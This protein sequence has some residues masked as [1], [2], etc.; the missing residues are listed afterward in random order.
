[1]ADDES[2][3]SRR[4]RAVLLADMKDYSA[5]MGEDEA[6]AI[7]GVDD[8]AAVFQDVVRRRGGTYEIGSGDRFFAIFDSAVEAL[9]AALEIQRE[10]AGGDSRR[11]RPLAI[12]IGIHLGEVVVTSFGPMG[13]SINIAARIQSIAEPGGISV[14]E[15]VYR[16]VRSRLTD[17]AFRDTG[18]QTLKNI[19]ERI[20]VYAV[21]ASWRTDG[22]R[23]APVARRTVL[24]GVATL[25]AA[26]AG[27]VV[28]HFLPSRLPTI[29][30]PEGRPLVLGVMA[31]RANGHVPEW[32]SD[33]TRDGLNTVLSKQPRLLVYSRQKIDFLSEKRGL[34]ELEVAEQLGISKMVSASLSDV[35]SELSLEVQIIDIKTGLIEGSHESRGSEKQLIEMQN[36]AAIEV[37]RSLKLP[38]DEAEVQKLLANRTNDRLDDYKLLTE[39]MGGGV[40]PEPPGKPRS[41]VPAPWWARLGPRTAEASEDDEEAIRALLERYRAAL[42]SRDMARVESLHAALPTPM[43]DALQQYFGSAAR[44]RVQFSQLDIVVEGDEA[45]ATFTRSDDFLDAQTGMP[46]HLE[47]RVSNVLTRREGGWKILGLKKPS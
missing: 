40:E 33:F 23:S 1:M 8:I 44:L 25:A 13:D 21:V 12:R 35:D 42:E 11:S 37:M 26:G 46:V 6:H 17:V 9:E 10:L 41:A 22:A 5:L 28:W 39:S 3:M 34:R 36:E 18:L 19:R 27:W 24:V 16:A 38:I 2:R 32:M 47:V 4:L 7:A 20:R 30:Q 14:S 31:I 29:A 43:R 15:D 45:L